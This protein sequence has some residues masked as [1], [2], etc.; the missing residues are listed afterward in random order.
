MN[1][2][3]I[4]IGISILVAVLVLFRVGTFIVGKKA[5]Q[6]ELQLQPMLVK[7]APVEKGDMDE[8][9]TLT[10]NVFGQAEVKVFP[11]VPGKL[12]KKI[13]NMLDPNGIMNPGN[14]EVA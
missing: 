8:V 2:K 10:G 5:E 12:M 14:W 4:W 6:K 13:K 11:K 3:K 9:L 1:K 7:A